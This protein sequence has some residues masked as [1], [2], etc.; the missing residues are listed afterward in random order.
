MKC[1]ILAVFLIV[2]ISH[3]NATKHFGHGGGKIIKIFVG[4]GK[5]GGFGGGHGGFG[6]GHGGY[7]GGYGGEH[8]G[9]GGGYGGFG[10]GFGGFGFGGFGKHWGYHKYKD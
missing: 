5:G 1:L 3:V 4:G 8:G 6:G 9:Y 7:G 2:I 10:G